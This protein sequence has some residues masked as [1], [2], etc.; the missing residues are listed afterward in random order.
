LGLSGPV[1]RRVNA[2]TKAGLLKLIGQATGAGWEHRRA[3][4]Y[5]ELAESRAW[6]LRGSTSGD[7]RPSDA[8]SARS[9]LQVR[10]PQVRAYQD[11]ALRVRAP[12]VRV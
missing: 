2:V 3:C 8:L 12:Q 7:R 1:P 4:R 9:C 6:R 5:L 10:A 11:R